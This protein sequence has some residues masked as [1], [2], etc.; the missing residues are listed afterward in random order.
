MK[1]NDVQI[2][3]IEK[4]KRKLKP[5]LLLKFLS[6]FIIPGQIPIKFRVQLF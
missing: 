2:K 5:F 4:K 1:E 3:R 6:L